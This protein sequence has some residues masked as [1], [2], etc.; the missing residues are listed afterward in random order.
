MK[1]YLMFAAI[2]L[3]VGLAK[4]LFATPGQPAGQGWCMLVEYSCGDHYGNAWAC[5][6]HAE[7][8]KCESDQMQKFQSVCSGSREYV[9]C[10]V[11]SKTCDLQQ[12]DADCSGMS[13]TEDTAAS[14]MP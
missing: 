5:V 1:K 2:V 3:S 7:K 9:K 10:Q 12:G 11:T 4:P 13:T 14:S 8:D 6:P